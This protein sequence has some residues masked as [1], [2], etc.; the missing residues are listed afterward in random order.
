M[1]ARDE[2][3]MSAYEARAWKALMEQAQ[4]PD[5]E[6]G[7][8]EEI[9]QGGREQ[10]RSAADRAA[11][12][13]KRLPGAEQIIEV[14]DA[15]TKKALAGLHVAFVERGLNS[16]SQVAIFKSFAK[17]GV[18]VSSF[19]EIRTLDLQRCDQTMPK[20][21]ERYLLL[22]AAQGALT[23]AVVTGTEVA[24]RKADGVTLRV[25]AAAVAADVSAVMVGM[26]RIVGLVGAHY[27]Y[28]VRLPEE[29]VFAT[30]VLA[31][32]T[33]TGAAE[34]SASL[35]ALSRL[36]QLMM[37]RATWAQLG[38]HQMVKIIQRVVTT[39]G[40]KL[41]KKKLAQA[42]P[43]AGVVVNGGMNAFLANN[44]FRSAQQAYRLR[45]LT[46]KYGLDAENWSPDM[47]DAEFTDLPLIDEIVEA[48]LA[49][50]LPENDP[51]DE[52]GAGNDELRG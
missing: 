11:Q 9:F 30:G 48:E 50:E 12:T 15:T 29:Q 47:V 32:S 4:R 3:P 19:D 8:Y 45:F 14:L 49:N 10:L 27:G 26:G 36:T 21:K 2:S 6:S 33:A 51:T 43:I 37:G 41:T 52:T 13:M 16:V 22:A 18:R 20:R 25:V 39:L 34:K 24:T 5:S 35:A 44:T 46:E 31:Y 28:D 42:V 23:A 1:T 17:Q 7:R 38:K 40:F